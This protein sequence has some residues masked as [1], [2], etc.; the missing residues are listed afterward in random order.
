MR[1]VL[2]KNFC[3][4]NHSLLWYTLGVAF[5][6]ILVMLYYSEL[7]FCFTIGCSLC[8]SASVACVAKPGRG[9]SVACVSQPV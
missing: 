9:G 6:G 8:S 7:L 5:S 2:N 1:D 4:E 3:L